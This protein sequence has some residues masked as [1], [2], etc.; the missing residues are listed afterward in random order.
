VLRRSRRPRVR[1]VVALVLA[2][3]ALLSVPASAGDD[4]F[5][6]GDTCKLARQREIE[7]A[8]GSPVVEYPYYDPLGDFG[9]IRI[10]AGG[11]QTPGGGE[12]QMNQLFPSLPTG[13]DTPKEVFEDQRAVDALGEAVLIDLENLGR[14]AYVNYTEGS[15]IVVATKKFAFEIGWSDG[16]ELAPLTEPDARKLIALSRK[17]VKRARREA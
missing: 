16:D 7:K 3:L 10:V 12:L 1:I 15:V 8:F 11:K 17:V 14:M 5:P 2:A 4:E 9:C 6:L 13:F